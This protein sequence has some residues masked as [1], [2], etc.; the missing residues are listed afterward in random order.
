[1][2]VAVDGQYSDAVGRYFSEMYAFETTVKGEK[3]EYRIRTVNDPK[4]SARSSYGLEAYMPATFV[5]I[6]SKKGVV[7]K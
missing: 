2:P 3:A 6:L 1:M 5:G 7:S 4:R